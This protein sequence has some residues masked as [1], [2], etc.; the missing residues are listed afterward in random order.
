MAININKFKKVRG[1]NKKKHNIKWD[2]SGLLRRK[3]TYANN[4]NIGC[5]EIVSPKKYQVSKNF[6]FKLKSIVY[7]SIKQS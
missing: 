3:K 2:T 1:G 7:A 6:A 4:P 5:H